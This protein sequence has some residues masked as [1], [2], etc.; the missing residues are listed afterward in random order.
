ML[1]ISGAIKKI[2]KYYKTDK[3]LNQAIISGLVYSDVIYDIPISDIDKDKKEQDKWFKDKSNSEIIK[4]FKDYSDKYEMIELAQ[5][6]YNLYV[7][8]QA[9]NILQKEYN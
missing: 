3:N 6:S 4:F 7:T 5:Y 8:L 9:I 2:K 1:D